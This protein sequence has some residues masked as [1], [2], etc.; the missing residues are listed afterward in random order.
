[1]EIEIQCFGIA[2]DICGADRIRLP[3]QEGQ[4]VGQLHRLLQ[5]KYP[6][7]AELRHFFIARNQQ[8]A[9][10]SEPI[11]PGDELV[12]IPPVSGG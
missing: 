5:E 11:M 2:R 1:M 9:E 4:Q 10:D 8:Y 6:A 3:L 7:L 12:I